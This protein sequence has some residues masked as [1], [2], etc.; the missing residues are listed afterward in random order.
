MR[1]INRIAI[2]AV[3]TGFILSAAHS[4]DWTAVGRSIERG[5]SSQVLSSIWD[6]SVAN[7]R[8]SRLSQVLT[9]D[10]KAGRYPSVPSVYRS[11]LLPVRVHYSGFTNGM[12]MSK[13]ITIPLKPSASMY[14][15]P[16][17]QLVFYEGVEDGGIYFEFAPMRESDYQRLQR[18]KFTKDISLVDGCGE[19]SFFTKKNGSVRLIDGAGC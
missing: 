5:E 15:L 17:T 12:E 10:A 4:A 1:F 16:I 6:A 8:T 11:D 18:I 9:R 2:M 3:A 7:D 14:G 13:D 19:Y